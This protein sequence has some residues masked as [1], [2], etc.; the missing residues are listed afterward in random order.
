MLRELGTA[1]SQPHSFSL[2]KY[3]MQVVERSNTAKGTIWKLWRLQV[4]LDTIWNKELPHISKDWGS[5]GRGWPWNVREM[6][7]CGA[8]A[9]GLGVDLAEWGWWLDSKILEILSL[10]ILWFYEKFLLIHRVSWEKITLKQ[11]CFGKHKYFELTNVELH[12]NTHFLN[13]FHSG[14][15]N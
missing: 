1:K 6:G 8:W 13:Y 4:W 10:K 7:R 9:Q 11:E 15:L 2:G 14:N 12:V 3:A 5:I